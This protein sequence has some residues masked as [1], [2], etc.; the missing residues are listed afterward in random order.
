MNGKM[1]KES[2]INQKEIRV[3]G[4]QRSGNHAIIKWIAHQIKGRVCFLNNAYPPKDLNPF[5]TCYP[6]TLAEFSANY[7]YDLEAESRGTLTKKECLIH[8]YEDMSFSDVFNPDFEKQHDVL[9]G[10]SRKRF[11]ILILRD[12]FNM[13][14]SRLK[15]T[16]SDKGYYPYSI[17]MDCQ[18]NRLLLANLW[19]LYAR[20]FIGATNHIGCNKIPVSFNRWASDQSYRK[21]ISERLGLDFTDTGM[22]GRA[23]DSSFQA[24]EGDTVNINNLFGRWRKYSEDPFFRKIFSDNELVML[25]RKIFGEIPGTAAL[26]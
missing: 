12:P 14:A 4:M 7:D 5:R 13:F 10:S 21:A 8:S 2:Y 17:G 3:L 25:S 22:T 24:E 26:L 19:I 18:R 16:R 20:E 15:K 11:D 9:V 23:T 6:N 1:E